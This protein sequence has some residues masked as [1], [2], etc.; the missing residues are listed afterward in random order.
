M[1]LHSSWVISLSSVR[2]IVMVIVD[3]TQVHFV[4]FSCVVPIFVHGVIHSRRLVM[5]QLCNWTDRSVISR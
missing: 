3:T 1:F 4:S 2:I 5:V